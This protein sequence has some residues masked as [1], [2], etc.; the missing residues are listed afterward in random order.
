MLDAV[1]ERSKIADAPLSVI[2]LAPASGDAASGDFPHP[3]LAKG[4]AAAGELEAVVRDW[5]AWLDQRPGDSELLMVLDA[6]ASEF[7]RL[8]HPRLRLVRQVAPSGLGPSLQ[9]GI[10]LA[11][12]PLVLTAPADRQFQ[13]ADAQAL[14]AN[15]D[16]VDFVAG[17]RVAGRPPLW[18]RGLGLL[19]RI[20]TR[21]LLGYADEPRAGW[22]G[23]TGFW[24]R[25]RTRCIF[26]VQLQ[27]SECPLRL[28]RAEVL[29]RFP[30]Q[31]RGSFAVIEVAA[32][33]NDLGCWM[34]EAPVPWKRPP[35]E[36]VDPHW[37][38][39]ARLVRRAPDF[40]RRPEL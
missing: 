4:G 27:D 16:Q 25:L 15:I 22:L 20:L 13:P 26:G 35:V 34:A 6:G 1:P 30:I 29:R 19:K 32:K 17:C 37:N 5:L 23:W 7:H 31:A 18:L 38:A 8:S 11:R 28:Y 12:F 3:P 21:V 9:T 10:W 39:D 36:T 2:L 33:A 40:G 24:R 14:F